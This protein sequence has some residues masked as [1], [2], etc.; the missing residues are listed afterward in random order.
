MKKMLPSR[1]FPLPLS[2]YSSYVSTMHAWYYTKKGS[3]LLIREKRHPCHSF[4]NLI[5]QS[6]T[7]VV[8][9]ALPCES[10]CA[11][12]PFLLPYREGWAYIESMGTILLKYL[13]LS[14]SDRYVSKLFSVN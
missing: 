13:V 3:V 14:A 12:N 4:S 1:P 2:S 7:L 8:V 11:L 10:G 6:I 5:E 9:I